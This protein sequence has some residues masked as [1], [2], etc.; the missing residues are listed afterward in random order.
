M[1]HAGGRA[2]SKHGFDILTFLE[3]SSE[4]TRAL[5]KDAGFRA[6]ASLNELIVD[7]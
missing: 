7:Y 6:S 2:L 1:G 3:E 5:A 4:R